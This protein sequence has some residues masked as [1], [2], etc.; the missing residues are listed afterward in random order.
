MKTFAV[1]RQIRHTF[2]C[3][4]CYCATFRLH[5]NHA[6]RGR[7]LAAISGKVPSV[8]GVWW[9]CIVHVQQT[10]NYTNLTTA[11]KCKKPNLNLCMC[12]GVGVWVLLKSPFCVKHPIFTNISWDFDNLSTKTW[13]AH[14][15]HTMF[16]VQSIHLQAALWMEMSL[17]QIKK[18]PSFWE[19]PPPSPRNNWGPRCTFFPFFI[20][21]VK[22]SILGNWLQKR[23]PEARVKSSV[24][25]ER[26]RR[27]SLP[28]AQEIPRSGETNSQFLALN[29]CKAHTSSISCSY[30]VC[31][32]VCAT[33]HVFEE[34]ICKTC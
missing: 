28:E 24:K 23:A 27:E 15:L 29:S 6:R 18:I 12:A 17:S 1:T 33:D 14:M 32:I 34:L 4:S 13:H 7:A 31:D 9:Y 5:F 21:F 8:S 25:R 11:P 22:D 20:V 16:E 2:A 19:W 3:V 10:L 30:L 26:R